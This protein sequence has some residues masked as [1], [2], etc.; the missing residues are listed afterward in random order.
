MC[1]VPALCEAWPVALADLE[2]PALCIDL[3][4][5]E[6]NERAAE[7]LLR[8]ASPTV[9]ARPHVKS[10]KC[11][12][13]G[14]RQ[15]ER[16][17]FT[18]GLSA[19]TVAE[20]AAMAEEA[21]CVDIL[22]TNQVLSKKKL[23]RLADICVQYAPQESTQPKD[24]SGADPGFKFA[25]RVCVDSEKGL[26]ALSDAGVSRGVVLGAVV[27]QNVGQGRCGVENAAQVVRLA[28]LATSDDLAGVR[29]CGI[30]GY[31]GACQHDRSK[32]SRDCTSEQVARTLR[33][34]VAALDREGLS[35]ARIVT[36]G[37]TGTF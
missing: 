9:M 30:Q 18:R 15:M 4:A 20:V 28:K 19:A 37:G 33:E 34:T 2:T 25:L 23:E 11:P 7:A 22:L 1:D 14:K 3:D 6:A 13:L 8:K 12:Y 21:G 29:F 10:H 17:G 32:A 5:L 27:E 35:C 26:R 16:T 36:G 24:C 31:H